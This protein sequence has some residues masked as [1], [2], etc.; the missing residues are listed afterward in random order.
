MG[1]K[2]LIY[3]HGPGSGL[4]YYCVRVDGLWCDVWFGAAGDTGTVISRQ[5]STV[6]DAEALVATRISE[7]RNDGFAEVSISQGA[8]SVIPALGPPKDKL[9]AA[10]KEANRGVLSAKLCEVV[11]NASPGKV[12]DLLEKG[13]DANARDAGGLPAFH[14][15]IRNVRTGLMPPGD[16]KAF[17]EHGVDVDLRDEDGTT[18]LHRAVRAATS[19]EERKLLTTEGTKWFPL[20]EGCIVERLLDAGADAN[21]TDD[22]GRTPLHTWASAGWTN[23]HMLPELLRA[24][25]RLE[26]R[27]VD[28]RTPLLH[29]EPGSREE[30]VDAEERVLR[31][32]DAGA[33]PLVKDHSG[34]SLESVCET[35]AK[36]WNGFSRVRER[37]GA[38]AGA[39]AEFQQLLKSLTLREPDRPTGGLSN[40][41]STGEL[42]WVARYL[43]DG[44]EP[45]GPWRD[46]FYPV[47]VAKKNGDDAML[48]LLLKA[49]ATDR[50]ST[51][52]V[53]RKRRYER[54]REARRRARA[55]RKR[56]RD[57]RAKE[58]AANIERCLELAATDSIAM[59][60]VGVGRERAFTHACGNGLGSLVDLFLDAGIDANGVSV[61]ALAKPLLFAV[62]ARDE[63][64]VEKL[65]AAGA[66]PNFADAM[67]ERQILSRAAYQGELS[68][69]R[70]LVEAG[71]DPLAAKTNF[72]INFANG[73][74]RNAIRRL[75]RD[76]CAEKLK[77]SKR[78]PVLFKKRKR[79]Y[80]A[81][82]LVDLEEYDAYYPEACIAFVEA[83]LDSLR[84]AVMESG[85]AKEWRSRL[86]K[87]PVPA[88]AQGAFLFSTR[89]SPRWCIVGLAAAPYYRVDGLLAVAEAYGWR[90]AKSLRTGFHDR[91]NELRGPWEDRAKGSGEAWLSREKLWVPPFYVEGEGQYD[92]GDVH[93]L[94]FK[95]ITADDI[96]RVDHL[97]WKF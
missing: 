10:R 79:M 87:G 52:N 96:V 14:L 19:E 57:A 3:K 45:E 23:E 1:W 60:S 11:T 46:G 30:L 72:P 15:C 51:V 49:G 73:P 32:L 54:A 29:A 24:G 89:A 74:Q 44:A 97:T 13:A 35:I 25:A 47:E 64:M 56:G 90:C 20:L 81:G 80:D 91:Q 76:S 8:D 58:R 62:H 59:A 77:K 88:V 92:R 78:H 41:V 6:D 31:L 17:I 75:L 12:G 5:Y 83:D 34:R 33:A 94:C 63:A 16:A 55:V 85:Q 40:A 4:S 53:E 22:A 7:K 38:K 26:L 43:E 48:H 21:A 2:R 28:G 84:D 36:S 71:A 50:P 61:R 86:T 9:T 42:A 69:V 27:D 18:A 66:D 95:G 67:G 82:A 39:E 37:L 93:R 70:L 68:M 65:L